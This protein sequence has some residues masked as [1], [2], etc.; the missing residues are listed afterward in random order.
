MYK[1]PDDFEYIDYQLT[2]EGV[3]REIDE[4]I[5]RI[6]E[7]NGE[8]EEIGGGAVTVKKFGDKFHVTVRPGCWILKRK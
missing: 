7:S 8:I 3:Q 4:D 1:F 5:A 2:V 6:N